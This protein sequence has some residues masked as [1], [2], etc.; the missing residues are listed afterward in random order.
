MGTKLTSFPLYQR[1][2][3]STRAFLEVVKTCFKIICIIVNY[4]ASLKIKLLMLQCDHKMKL[5]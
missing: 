4:F 2:I 1:S 5:L 3:L